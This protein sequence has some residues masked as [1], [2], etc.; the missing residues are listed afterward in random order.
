[1]LD[2]DDDYEIF[3]GKVDLQLHLKKQQ[4]QNID[5]TTGTLESS[6]AVSIV[7]D[8]LIRQVS[9]RL[10]QTVR[11]IF[12]RGKSVTNDAIPLVDTVI[13]IPVKNCAELTIGS[14]LFK[15]DEDNNPVERWEVVAFD[16]ATLRTRW[17]AAC[18]SI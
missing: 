14:H 7:E 10:A 12:E 9:E 2:L 13:E 16:K 6:K 8:C 17:R 1:M 18:R 15:L 5:F 11:Q 3:D 4:N